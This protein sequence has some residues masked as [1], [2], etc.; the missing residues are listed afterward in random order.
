MGMVSV[1]LALADYIKFKFINNDT[2]VTV[3][4]RKVA[5]KSW[6]NPNSHF[7]CCCICL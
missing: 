6:N 4:T 5:N 7:S 2:F 1:M 3:I